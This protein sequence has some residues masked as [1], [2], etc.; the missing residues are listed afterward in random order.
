MNCPKCGSGTY[1]VDSRT[2]EFGVYRRRECRVCGNR[3][4]TTETDS[5]SFRRLMEKTIADLK[6]QF[7]EAI[8]NVNKQFCN[9]L[10]IKE[11]IQ[12]EV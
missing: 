7:D 9:S 3:I 5:E 8:D 2:K 6:G 10:N 4:S 11:R 1:V 12:N